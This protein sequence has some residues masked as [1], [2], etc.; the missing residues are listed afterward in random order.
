M[1]QKISLKNKKEPKG[2]FFFDF[3]NFFINFAIINLN[4]LL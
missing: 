2:F 4:E 1:T 3:V